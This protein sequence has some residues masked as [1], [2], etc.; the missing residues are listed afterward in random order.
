ML[1]LLYP[2]RQDIV[3]EVMTQTIRDRVIDMC[4]D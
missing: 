2:G 1:S 4:G 3:Q